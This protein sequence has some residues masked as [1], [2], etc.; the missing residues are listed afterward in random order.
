VLDGE[1]KLAEHLR[2]TGTSTHAAI[3]SAHAI[4]IRP[5]APAGSRRDMCGTAAAFVSEPWSTMV[6]RH[7]RALM[8]TNGRSLS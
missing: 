6:T 7:S 8:E 3:V 2:S 5:P 1:P 4:R